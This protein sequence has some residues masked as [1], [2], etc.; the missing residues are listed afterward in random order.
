MLLRILYNFFSNFHVNSKKGF[1]NFFKKCLYYFAVLIFALFLSPVSV[2]LHLLG[3]RVAN[4]LT[5]RVGH[6]ALEPFALL[7][8]NNNQDKKKRYVILANPKNVANYELLQIWKSSFLVVESSVGEF[9]WKATCIFGLCFADMAGCL[10]AGS[11]KFRLIDLIKNQ[12]TPIQWI[13]ITNEQN[14]RAQDVMNDLGCSGK[15]IVC[16]H[17]RSE[18]YSIIDDDIQSYRNT[19]FSNYLPSIKM[20]LSRGYIV[21]VFGQ[22]KE[23]IDFTHKNL[24]FV[25]DIT[26]GSE[27][28][29][30]YCLSTCEFFLGNTSGIAFVASIFGK[31]LALANVVPVEALPF[32]EH[33][34]GMFKSYYLNGLKLTFEKCLKPEYSGFF[35]TK[36]FCD[37][38]IEL[39]ENSPDEILL[40]CDWMITRSGIEKKFQLIDVC[41]EE[42]HYS[43]GTKAKYFE[44]SNSPT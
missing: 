11:N 28:F 21:V 10:A 43:F 36:K 24:V 8:S 19:T 7:L 33:D 26:D 35:R 41:Y 16:V 30:L 5:N 29:Q 9:F 18:G 20:L 3:Y 44:V 34:V 31:P 14:L 39:V 32:F 12:N 23:K 17:S 1:W 37:H 42:T 25:C 15:G 38:K 4:I 6:L 40:M 22:D 13:K 2:C 27:S